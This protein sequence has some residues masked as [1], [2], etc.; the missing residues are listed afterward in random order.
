MNDRITVRELLSAVLMAAVAWAIAA[1]VF[2][3]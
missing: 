2:S 3:L 1:L